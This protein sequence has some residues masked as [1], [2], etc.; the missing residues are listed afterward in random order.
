MKKG[1]IL[2]ICSLVF[3]TG[4]AQKQTQEKKFSFKVEGTIKNFSGKTVYLTHKLNET[5]I[6]DSAKVTNGKFNFN[7]KNTEPSIYWFTVNGDP[8]MVMFLQMKLQ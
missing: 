4:I 6:R 3:A 1:N 5:E 8:N 2:I 7:L